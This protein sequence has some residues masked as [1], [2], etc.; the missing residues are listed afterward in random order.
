MRALLSLVVKDLRLLARDRGD[1]FFVLVWP[2]VVAIFFGLVFSPGRGPRG[3]IALAVVDEDKTAGSASFLDALGRQEG[4]ALE[5]VSREQAVSLVRRAKKTA[6]V[7][8]L[9]G[10]G[11]ARE[12]MF[13]GEPARIEVGA[14]PSRSGE[15]AM[16]EGLLKAEAFKGMQALFTD[17]EAAGRMVGKAR[18]ELRAAPAEQQKTTGRFLEELDRYLTATR[19]NSAGS[20][21]ASAAAGGWNP[22]EIEMKSVAEQRA[23]PKNAFEITFPQGILWGILGCAASFGVGLVVE[24]K[25]GTLL[26][27][28]TAPLSRAQI[29]AGR[30]LACMVAILLVEAFLTAIGVVVFHVRP[31]SL[32]HFAMAG[33]AAALGFSGLMMGL[34]VIGRT[35][36]SVGGLCWALLLMMSMLGG[37]MMP[38]FAMPSWMISASHLSPV[39]WAILALEGGLWRGFSTAE[40]LLPCGILLAVGLAGLAL[41]ARLYPRP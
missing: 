18:G 13:Y 25:Q 36:Q 41:G 24:R 39:K 2:L 6:Y 20:A 34:S 27:L 40:M 31:S 7:V 29:L 35:P 1:L 19:A 28:E 17:R 16:L 12:R 22:V 15:M 14:D 30:G 3:K 11:E 21:G 37:G 10:F 23:G 38:L 33:V 5:A 8:L 26:R 9:P 32:A 4:L